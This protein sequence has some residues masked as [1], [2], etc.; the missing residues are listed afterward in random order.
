VA[1]GRDHV[2]GGRGGE[3]VAVAVAVRD[4]DTRPRHVDA[5]D[6]AALV[7]PDADGAGTR[8]ERGVEVEPRRDDGVVTVA[9]E[10]QL[11]DAALRRAQHHGGDR[12]RR[13]NPG[14]GHAQVLEQPQGARGEAV[15]T[16]L[17]AGKGRAVET[18]DAQ[19]LLLGGDGRRDP[20]GTGTDDEDV[21]DGRLVGPRSRGHARNGTDE[22]AL[23]QCRRFDGGTRPLPEW[24]VHLF[25]E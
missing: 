12:L 18:R 17:V 15:A 25:S 8:D 7:H 5:G 10:R 11:A 23:R 2:P 16:G 3:A 21:E 14:H 22:G 13:R 6:R 19:A 4:D 20:R 1:V 9:R 24:P